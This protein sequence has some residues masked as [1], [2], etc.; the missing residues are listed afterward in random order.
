MMNSVGFLLLFRADRRTFIL[1]FYFAVCITSN[2][3]PLEAEDLNTQLQKESIE[4]ELVNRQRNAAQIIVRFARRLLWKKQA[5]VVQQIVDMNPPPDESSEEFQLDE[6][7]S[8][9]SHSSTS[10]DDITM[11]ARPQPQNEDGLVTAQ[12]LNED[13]RLSSDTQQANEVDHNFS[14]VVASVIPINQSDVQ[15]EECG[16][17]KEKAEAEPNKMRAEAVIS[18]ILHEQPKVKQSPKQKISAIP[19]RDDQIDKAA[20]RLKLA[21]ERREQQAVA[22]KILPRVERSVMKKIHHERKEDI[23]KKSLP[24][25]ANQKSDADLAHLEWNKKLLVRR[26]SRLKTKEKVELEA[27]IVRERNARI[28]QERTRIVQQQA[29]LVLEEQTRNAKNATRLRLSKESAELKRLEE[30]LNIPLTIPRG[31]ENKENDSNFRDL[32]QWTKA[33]SDV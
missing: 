29:R 17:E 16:M 18:R 11:N 22:K 26:E 14:V 8:L 12:P 7:S 21:R 5:P 9:S 3:L 4:A 31:D 2:Y 28:E 24:D 33:L 25:N 6:S 20:A 23:T 15:C 30:K 19:V 10:D 27:A 13:D 1:I 32:K